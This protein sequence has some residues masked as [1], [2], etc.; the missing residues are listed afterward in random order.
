MHI[1]IR[2][3]DYGTNTKRGVGDKDGQM[4]LSQEGLSS[5]VS[6]RTMFRSAQALRLFERFPHA[7]C[8]RSRPATMMKEQEINIV[9]IQL[10]DLLVD[11]A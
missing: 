5:N 9:S 11:I 4:P 6:R 2:Y 1:E 8:L 3:T 7:C 10:P